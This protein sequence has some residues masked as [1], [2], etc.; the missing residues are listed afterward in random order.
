MLDLQEDHGGTK[1]DLQ[2]LGDCALNSELNSLFQVFLK[3]RI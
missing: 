2:V 1:Q 3:G